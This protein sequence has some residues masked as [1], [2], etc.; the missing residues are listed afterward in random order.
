MTMSRCDSVGPGDGGTG[1]VLAPQGAVQTEFFETVSADWLYQAV[2][3]AAA[4]LLLLSM[5]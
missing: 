1:S 5:V 2:A 4:V 3:A